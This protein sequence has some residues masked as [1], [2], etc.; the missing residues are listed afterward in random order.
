M[1]LALPNRLLLFVLLQGEGSAMSLTIASSWPKSSHS[2][3]CC[4]SNALTSSISV[5]SFSAYSFQRALSFHTLSSSS[6]Q[7]ELV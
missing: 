7:L 3:V 6:T 4:K 5:P 2:S 1:L